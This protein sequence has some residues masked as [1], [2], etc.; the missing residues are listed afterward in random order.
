VLCDETRAVGIV[1]D[2]CTF[3]FCDAAFGRARFSS[4]RPLIDERFWLYIV[5]E[6]GIN[7][8]PFFSIFFF[9]FFGIL[10]AHCLLIHSPVRCC[11]V[12]KCPGP[13]LLA[14]L[15]FSILQ[16]WSL[17]PFHHF[18][19]RRVRIAGCIFFYGFFFIHF[20]FC[21]F[22]FLFFASSPPPQLYEA[23]GRLNAH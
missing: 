7:V 11:F 19:L 5:L 22:F 12:R 8:V 6:E 10:F 17:S 18:Y 1:D 9:Y 2:I 16:A 20:F 3:F 13:T 21:L 14:I 4:G 15:F 23:F